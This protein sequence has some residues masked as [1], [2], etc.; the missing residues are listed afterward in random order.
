MKYIG[1][2]NAFI[3]SPF[4]LEGAIHGV[5]AASVASAALHGFYSS[6]IDATANVFGTIIEIVSIN[7]YAFIIWLVFLFVGVLCGLLGSI[8][9]ISKNLNA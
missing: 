9:S 8:F 3:L 5:I 4:I 2:T 1:A 7:D 6:A